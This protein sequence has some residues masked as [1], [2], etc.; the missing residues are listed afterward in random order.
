MAEKLSAMIE[1]LASLARD[2]KIDWSDAWSDTD[3]QDFTAAAARRADLD[4][5]AAR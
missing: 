2:T 3:L 4:E 1:R 5:Q